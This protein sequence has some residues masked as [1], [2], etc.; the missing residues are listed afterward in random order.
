M[1]RMYKIVNN[2]VPKSAPALTDT[3]SPEAWEFG[4]GVLVFLVF[5]FAAWMIF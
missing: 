1:E 5:A 4:C 3:I 2:D